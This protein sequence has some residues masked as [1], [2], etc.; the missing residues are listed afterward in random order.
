[1]IPGD[2]L[3]KN[4]A[5]AFRLVWQS[6]PLLTVSNLVLRFMQAVLPLLG[7]YLIK[8]IVDQISAGLNEPDRMAIFREI[9]FLVILSGCVVLL[10]RVLS[11]LA[12]LVSTS[13]ADAV[14]DR[15][16]EILHSKSIEMDLEYYENSE[17]YDSLHRA[18]REA[19]Y[20]PTRIVDGMFSCGQSGI[21]L[22][23]I[24]GLLL[25]FHWS[26]PGFL[27][28]A[29]IPGLLVR[30]R[31]AKRLYIWSRSR[32]P[33]ERQAL[34]FDAILTGSNY[35][36]EIRLFALGNI[37]A[38]RFDRLRN[39]IRRERLDLLT[40]RSAADLVT[41]GGAIIPTFALFGFLAYRAVHGVMTIGDLVMFYQAVQRGQSYLNQFVTSIAALYENN[42]F[43]SN[44]HEFLALK[45]KITEVAQPKS[46]ARPLQSGIVF[47]DVSF[48]YPGSDR[49]VLDRVTFRI[50]SGEHIAL[51]GENGSGKTTL[52]KLLSRLYDPTGGVITFDGRDIRE[53]SL[54][55]LRQRITVVFQDY[56]QYHLTAKENIWFG[57][58]ELPPKQ[59]HIVTA[60]RQAGADEAIS[61]LRAGYDTV[62]GKRF[63]DGEELSVGEWQKLALARAFI[64]NAEIIVL[65]EPTSALDPRAEYELFKKFHELAKGR[66][67]ILIS[68]RLST[69]RMADSIYVLENG[70][71]M[72]SGTHDQ[73]VS[74][75]GNYANLFE[76][77]AQYYR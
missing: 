8:L 67:A 50:R 33:T 35:A 52:V 18:Q 17:Y 25:T 30:F 53:L 40:K 41:Q 76:T 32:T 27:L 14:T 77:Q 70:K 65:D 75:G 49:A 43:I 2:K 54:R 10:E 24:G 29:A 11:T 19:P 69:V 66:T 74:D 59:D 31:F 6:G 57:N 36:K 12:S 42:L 63:E 39:R 44:L 73:L 51:V 26:V 7:I 68:H 15:M 45:P 56:A 71:I 34:Y 46:V 4:I 64:R 47:Q 5:W 61:K 58:V 16:Y 55:E 21:S 3:S 62:L 60:A 38:E 13:Q 1:M 72:E 37:F 23:A 22:I 48:H 20:R 28:L 9:L